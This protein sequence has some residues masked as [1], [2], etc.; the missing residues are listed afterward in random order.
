MGQ[1]RFDPNLCINCTLDSCTEMY[2]NLDSFRKH[3]YRKHRDVLC[4]GD[5]PEGSGDEMENGND[6]VA[7]SCNNDD[8]SESMEFSRSPVTLFSKRTS[9]LFLLKTREERKVTQTALNGIVQDMRSYWEEGMGRLKVCL[10]FVL[11]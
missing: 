11:S 10:L 5:N 4:P 8:V 3:I 1:H 7:E 6:D 9:A 2:S